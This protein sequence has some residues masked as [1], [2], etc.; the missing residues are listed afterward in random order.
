MPHNSLK[1]LDAE[2]ET[3][4]DSKDGNRELLDSGSDSSRTDQAPPARDV[5]GFRW[6]LVVISLISATFLWGLDGT[7]TADIQATFVRDFHSI[8]KLAYNSVGFFL[9]AAAV[10]LTWYATRC[11]WRY[12]SLCG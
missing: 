10:V 9:G 4:T 6:V 12:I 3:G 5:H 8:E 11:L 1:S 2:K 7:I